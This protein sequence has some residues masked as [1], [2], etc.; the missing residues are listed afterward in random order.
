[1]RRFLWDRVA[2]FAIKEPKGARRRF[3]LFGYPKEDLTT[4]QLDLKK[5]P[6][7]WIRCQPSFIMSWELVSIMFGRGGQHGCREVSTWCLPKM[8]RGDSLDVSSK[9]LEGESA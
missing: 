1:M 7:C 5:G 2:P 3:P 4:F 9:L 8:R 6:A